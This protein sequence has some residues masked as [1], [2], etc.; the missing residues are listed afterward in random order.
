MKARE[1]D[2]RFDNGEDISR[3]L[4]MTRA[5]KPEQEHK[6]VNVDFP[7]WM[8]RSD[9]TIIAG[10]RFTRL[11]QGKFVAQMAFLALPGR[12]VSSW[13]ANIV[14]RLAGEAGYIFTFQSVQ[15]ISHPVWRVTAF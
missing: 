14:A 8:I 13:F 9:V 3:Y 4:D 7:L 10:L 2:K 1:F 11:F 15:G 12:T 5:R 6:R